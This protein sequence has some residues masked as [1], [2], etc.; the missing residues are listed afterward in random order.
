M[1]YLQTNEVSDLLGW[2]AEIYRQILKDRNISLKNKMQ[3]I[4]PMSGFG[5]RFKKEGYKV[6]KPLIEVNGKPIINYILRCFQEKL[7]LLYM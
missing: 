5:E 3:I 6:P 4:I 2:E 7:I 1:K